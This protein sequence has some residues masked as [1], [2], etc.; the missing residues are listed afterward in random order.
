MIRQTLRA[1]EDQRSLIATELHDGPLQHLTALLYRL[2]AARSC[3]PSADDWDAKI[4]SF[5]D[6]VSSEI[7][8]IRRMMT[9]LQSRR[10]RRARARRFASRL[11]GRES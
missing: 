3:A 7:T 9:M 8:N 10:T 6:A 2:Q 1:S 11:R 5:Q 4:T